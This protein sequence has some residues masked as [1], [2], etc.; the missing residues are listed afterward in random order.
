MIN[1]R[2]LLGPTFSALVIGAI[3]LGAAPAPASLRKDAGRP[4]NDTVINTE[5]APG[6][7]A[8]ITVSIALPDTSDT[9]INL[10][11]SPGFFS[12]LPSQ[13]YV[14]AGQTTV[15]FTAHVSNTAAGTVLLTAYN[16]SG[17][18]VKAIAI[19]EPATGVPNTI[20]QF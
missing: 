8:S 19:A 13:V 4:P 10:S 15:T 18:F 17:Y 12:S 3:L 5:L 20:L 11:A 7:D 6:Q 1:L 14:R 9:V 2:R 16:S